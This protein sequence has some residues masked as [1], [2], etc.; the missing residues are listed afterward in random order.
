MTKYLNKAFKVNDTQQD[1][2]QGKKQLGDTDTIQENEDLKQQPPPPA[3]N[4][5][6]ER[7][8]GITSKKGKYNVIQGRIRK[9]ERTLRNS[10]CGKRNEKLKKGLKDEAEDI[11]QTEE[12]KDK[13]K[14]RE[15]NIRKIGNPS[16]RCNIYIIRVPGT[17]KRKNS[18]EKIIQ[19]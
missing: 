6:R 17:E 7:R 4:I 11:S 1:S 15:D 18:R 14:N 12:Q 3:I 13:N 9:P 2:K 19:E 16:R 5:M 10:N 8:E